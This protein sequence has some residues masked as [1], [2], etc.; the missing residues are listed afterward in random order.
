MGI[1]N[2][3]AVIASTWDEHSFEMMERWIA[4]LTA[5]Q[6]EHFVCAGPFVDNCHTIVLV[7]DGSKENWAWSDNFDVLR[8]RFVVRLSQSEYWKWVEVGFGEYGQKVLCGNC[9]NKFN[10]R[11]YAR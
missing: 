6:A 4:G 5:V 10:D 9:E 1:I 11:D 3:N 7:P 8:D 2:H